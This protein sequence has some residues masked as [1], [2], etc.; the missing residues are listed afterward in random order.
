MS[1]NP[2]AASLLYS[3]AKPATRPAPS[4]DSPGNLFQTGLADFA[5]TLREGEKTAAA[6][7]SG[8]ASMPSLVEALAKAELAVE[9]AVTVRNK[10]V[11]AYQEILRMPV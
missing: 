7:L 3:A 11:E 6:A 10:V 8:D 2:T 1:I 9:T 5:S 4:A